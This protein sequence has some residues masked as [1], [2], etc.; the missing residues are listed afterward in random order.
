MGE[1]GQ[2]QGE[3]W[4]KNVFLTYAKPSSVVLQGNQWCHEMRLVI[5]QLL[6]GVSGSQLKTGGSFGSKSVTS[7]MCRAFHGDAGERPM[8]RPDAPRH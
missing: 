5:L 7:P 8:A 2:N 6:L 1:T 3:L 4:P